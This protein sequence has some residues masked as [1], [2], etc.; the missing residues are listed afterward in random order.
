MK[1]FLSISLRLMTN[2]ESLNGIESIGNLSRHR[3]VPIV[4]RESEEGRR[5]T[6][7]FV[8]A[9]SGESIAH[10]YQELLVKFAQE[11]KVNV[12]KYS[13]Q[14]EFIK[15][16]DDNILKN[17][18]IS[19]PSDLEDIRRAEADIIYKDVIA[20]IGGFL[21]AGK[22]PIKRSSRFQIGYMIPAQGDINATALEAQFHV[23]HVPSEMKKGVAGE[24]R[25]QVPYNI[26]VGSAVYNFTFNLDLDGISR[27]STRFGKKTEREDE[28][29]QERSSRVKVAMRALIDLL[30][31]LQ[32]GAKRTRFLPNVEP[33]S[34]VVAYSK[35]S[36][37]IVSPGNYRGFIGTTLK[38][39]LDY[40]NAV[41]KIGKKPIINVLCFDK[42]GAT[43]GLDE[44]TKGEIS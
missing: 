40:Q 30:S 14:G 2:V 7:R 35:D 41:S 37:F 15:F 8:P 18:G 34:A 27:V 1:G 16:T 17:E 39:I 4:V 29:N 10:A 33:L 24:T 42:E 44:V 12:G 11:S 28:L 19:P 32:Y 6:I 26:E 5:Y 20:D 23:R 3:T 43:E 9:I 22:F 25:A 13:S 38:R 36:V 21:Y 31:S